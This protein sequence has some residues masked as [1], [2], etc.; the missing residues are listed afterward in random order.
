MTAMTAAA[1]RAAHLVVDSEPWI[2]EDSLA[3]TLLG[4]QAGPLL[5]YHRTHP[6]HDVLAVARAMA[7]TRSRFTEERLADAA[8]RGVAQYL[9]LGAGL[10]SFAWRSPL[11]ARVRVVEADHPGT[12]RWKRAQ[13]AAAS[14][15]SGLAARGEVRYA[16]T[17]LEAGRLDEALAGAGFDLSRPTLISWLGV[18]MYLTPATVASILATLGRCPPGTELVAEYLVPDDL[19]DDLGRSYAELVAPVA[20]EHG[21]P[22]RTF[23]RPEEM[24]ALLAAH[25]FAV[26]A[27]VPQR[28]AVPGALWDRADGLR[29]AGLSWLVHAR[30]SAPPG[31][32]PAGRG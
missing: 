1:A 4:D 29:P 13:L 11:A 16:E 18:I 31:D 5:G 20:A 7:T 17:D 8:G 24:A 6:T 10:D 23:L 30:R 15:R 9:I 27:H 2:F 22:W 28:A 25:G 32:W 3:A 26:V 21:E 14:T 19:R 12:Q